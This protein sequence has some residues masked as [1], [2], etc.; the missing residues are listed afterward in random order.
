MILGELL[1]SQ[2]RFPTNWGAK[3]PLESSKSQGSVFGGYVFFCG[4][5]QQTTNLG[6]TAKLGGGES[7]L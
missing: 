7:G 6:G 5:K 1:R 4:K 2:G 3:E